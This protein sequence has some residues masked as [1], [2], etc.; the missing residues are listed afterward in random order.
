MTSKKH[1]EELR[2]L[3]EKREKALREKRFKKMLKEQKAPRV[4]GQQDIWK[5]R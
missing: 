1:Q 3:N 4:W 5:D 2:I